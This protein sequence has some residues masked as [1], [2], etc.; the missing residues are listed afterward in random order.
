MKKIDKIDKIPF[1]V[2]NLAYNSPKSGTKQIFN[3]PYV[4]RVKQVIRKDGKTIVKS[5]LPGHK[6]GYEATVPDKYQVGIISTEFY[7]NF[8]YTKYNHSFPVYTITLETGD[9]LY[10]ILDKRNEVTYHTKEELFNS[11]ENTLQSN[12]DFI[13]EL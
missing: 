13:D 10:C 5:V 11:L 6:D 2:T 12:L 8:K 4:R 9:T 7:D 1:I 3:K